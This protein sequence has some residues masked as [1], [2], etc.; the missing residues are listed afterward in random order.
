M[1][2]LAS[3]VAANRDARLRAEERFLKLQRQVFP[4]IGAALHPAATASSAAT[5]AEDV[6]EA[7]QLSEDIA[8]VLKHRGIKARALPRT[9]AKSGMAIAVIDGA[10]VRVGQHGI[11]FADFLEFIFRVRI[12][13]IA[14]RMKLQRQLAIGAL[15]FLLRDRT[16][17]AQ[18]FVVV[19]FCVRRQNK[20]FFKKLSP[21]RLS[22]QGELS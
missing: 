4:K 14:V 16:G 10:L 13:G 20:P 5:T 22:S 1:T 3:L 6:A 21:N 17:H 19:A 7:E 2:F 9:A 11:G 8:E 12:V 15:E 18:H